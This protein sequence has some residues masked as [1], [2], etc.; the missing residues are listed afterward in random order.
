MPPLR[1]LK[2]ATDWTFLSELPMESPANLQKGRYRSIAQL[3]M[4]AG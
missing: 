1:L 4:T 2:L 3:N